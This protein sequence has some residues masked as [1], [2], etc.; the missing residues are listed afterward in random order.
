M[1]MQKFVQNLSRNLGTQFPALVGKALGRSGQLPSFNFYDPGTR[2]PSNAHFQ[3]PAGEGKRKGKRGKEKKK[4]KKEK[5]K[6]NLLFRL[7]HVL[8]RSKSIK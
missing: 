5:S 8:A 2:T 4:K 3:Q 6:S 1:K 7:P